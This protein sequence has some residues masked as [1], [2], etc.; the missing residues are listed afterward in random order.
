[1]LSSQQG[2]VEFVKTA[3]GNGLRQKF[4]HCNGIDQ[5]EKDKPLLLKGAG[6]GMKRR[7]IASNKWVV[8]VWG[9]GKDFVANLAQISRHA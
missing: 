5:R 9:G 3:G 6:G 4:G 8:G 1:M 7:E 2:K